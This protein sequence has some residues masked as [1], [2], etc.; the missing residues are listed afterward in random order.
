[1][2][3]LTNRNFSDFD[4]EINGV[5][6]YIKNNSYEAIEIINNMF[7]WKCVDY[8]LD[9]KRQLYKI[10]NLPFNDD[11][12]CV[13]ESCFAVTLD[14][15]DEKFREMGRSLDRTKLPIGIIEDPYKS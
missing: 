7:F 2:R 12:G 3:I 5:K 11:D 1:M 9:M 15:V 6:V 4:E 14:F 8:S 13:M 10:L